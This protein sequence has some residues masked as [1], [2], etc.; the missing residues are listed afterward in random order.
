MEEVLKEGVRRRPTYDPATLPAWKWFDHPPSDSLFQK[1]ASQVFKYC[2]STRTRTQTRARRKCTLSGL[3]DEL[4]VGA[5]LSTVSVSEDCFRITG[6]AAYLPLPTAPI[7]QSLNDSIS[8]LHTD[9]RWAAERIHC[10]DTGE[11]I[12]TRAIERYSNSVERRIIQRSPRD[13]RIRGGGT[14][15]RPPPSRSERHTG[16]PRRP[17]PIQRGTRRDYRNSSCH[18]LYL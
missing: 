6:T 15:V 8:N 1:R 10:D 12:A 3:V 9:I 4:P 17:I 2:P 13:C 14:N 5:L 7:A 16:V 11:E 18:P